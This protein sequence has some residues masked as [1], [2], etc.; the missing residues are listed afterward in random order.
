MNTSMR[1]AVG[2]VCSA[3]IATALGIGHAVAQTPPPIDDFFRV[4]AIDSAALSPSGRYLAIVIGNPGQR[5]L[6]AVVDLDQSGPGATKGI[7]RFADSDMTGVRWVDDQR[8]VFS[9]EDSDAPVDRRHALGLWAINR[10]GT[11]QRQ[12]IKRTW[13]EVIS[14]GNSRISRRLLEPDHA[15]AGVVQDG[16]GDVLVIQQ[17]W[18]NVGD[19]TG[20][21]LHRLDTRTGAI[22]SAGKAPDARVVDWMADA[23]GEPR[24]AVSMSNGR[25]RLYWRSPADAD[26]SLLLD[27]PATI[28]APIQPLW[29]DGT[30]LFVTA[31]GGPDGTS[32]LYRFDVAKRQLDAEPL[33][34]IDGFD[35]DG[36]WEYDLGTGRVVGIHYATDAAGSHWFD[37]AL[38]AA[39]AEVNAALPGRIN[40]LTCTRC[41]GVPRVLVRSHSDR[42]PPIWY[43]YDMKARKLESVGA[44]RPWIDAKKMA[45]Q[46]FVRIKARDGKSIPL[47][48][49]RP[50]GKSAEPRPA[51]V[52]VHGG[53]HVRGNVWGWNE[54]AQFLASRGYVVIEPEFRGSEGFGSAHLAAGFKQWGL[55]MQD[56]VT[57]ATLW[58][59]KE[60]GV[61]PKRICIAGASY[62]GYAALMGVV[63]EP[64]L[65][66]CAINWVGVTDPGLM[67]SISHSDLSEDSKRHGW[68]TM[69]GDPV[70]DKE[71]F[72]ATSPIAQAARIKRPLLLAYGGVD[73][74][75]PL[76]HG[77]RFRDAVSPHNKDVEWVV[78]GEEGHGWGDPKNTRDFWSRVEKF[79]A[80]HLGASAPVAAAV[81]AG[82]AR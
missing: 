76:D 53:P 19:R 66:R 6:L 7:T 47:Y 71:R 43:V 17:R 33:F 70:A 81:P 61:D 72:T 82:A 29:T 16:S 34:R 50:N 54:D 60:A 49:T 68:R 21:A 27:E 62:G 9:A 38:K 35:Y 36:S 31:R 39:Q 79:L 15:M 24:A 41:I 8:L 56:D 12:L 75:V 44:S 55:A 78:Y 26:W 58:A 3:L 18:D 11:E 37:P 40:R 57:D 67:F 28:G 4:P 74:R 10:D 32:A 48:I 1:A 69:L 5:R 20:Q 59:V 77:T 52:L 73:R 80:R 2:R 64:D 65:Y 30:D 22:R 51:V 13:T 42:Q 25:A 46:D 63:R 23:S 14:E 45:E